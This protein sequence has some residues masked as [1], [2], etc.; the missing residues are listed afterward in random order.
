MFACFVFFCKFAPDAA[1]TAKHW[2]V[3]IR[4]SGKSSLLL[5]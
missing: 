1:D 5:Y 4:F 2:G 3:A